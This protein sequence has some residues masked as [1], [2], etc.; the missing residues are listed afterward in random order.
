MVDSLVFKCMSLE[1]AEDDLETAM[2]YKS[3]LQAV[4][5]ANTAFLINCS[6]RNRYANWAVLHS[7]KKNPTHL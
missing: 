4:I 2:K 5:S 7:G 1:K 6:E 3:R